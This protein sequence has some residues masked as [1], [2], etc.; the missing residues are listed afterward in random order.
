MGANPVQ[1]VS[2]PLS[3]PILPGFFSLSIVQPAVRFP[4]N[5]CLQGDSTVREAHMGSFARCGDD[6]EIS[7]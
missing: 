5:R 6:E 7:F 3:I 4:A 1:G 2:S